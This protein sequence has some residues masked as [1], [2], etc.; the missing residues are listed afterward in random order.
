MDGNESPLQPNP[1]GFHA[2]SFHLYP[3]HASSP[4]NHSISDPSTT[5]ANVRES[6]NLGDARISRRALAPKRRTSENLAGKPRCRFEVERGMN[7]GYHSH[8]LPCS[9]HVSTDLVG[10][11]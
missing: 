3:Q 7:F 10:L 4:P 6:K 8:R 9:E 1:S 2:P 11:D 5:E